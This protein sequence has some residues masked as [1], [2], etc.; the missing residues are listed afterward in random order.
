MRYTITWIENG[1][2]KYVQRQTKKSAIKVANDNYKYNPSVC[3][4][5]SNQVAT[6]QEE[7]EKL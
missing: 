2:R 3:D 1:T 6:T 7:L 4:S 5:K